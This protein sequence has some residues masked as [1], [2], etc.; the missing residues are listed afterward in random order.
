MLNY[1]AGGIGSVR[2][3]EY[4]SLGPKDLITGDPLGGDRRLVANTEL[5]FPMPGLKGDKSVRLSLFADAGT[6]WG[7]EQYYDGTTLLYRNQKMDLSDLR[8]SAGFSLGWTSPVGPLKF[9]IAQP[10][11]PQDGDKIEKFQFTMGTMF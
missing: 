3:Y 11:R 4:A 10:I 2:G 7:P 1:Y 8:Y 9:S 6:V 5:L